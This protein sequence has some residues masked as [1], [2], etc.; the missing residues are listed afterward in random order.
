MVGGSKELIAKRQDHR[1]QRG[2]NVRLLNIPG[3][4]A[5]AEI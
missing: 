2:E 4:A 3:N 1:R 5:Q